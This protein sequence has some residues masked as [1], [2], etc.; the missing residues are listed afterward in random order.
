[1]IQCVS[2]S[3]NTLF[4]RLLLAVNEYELKKRETAPV[5]QT[6]PTG[7]QQDIRTLPDKPPSE[8]LLPR[9]RAASLCLISVRLGCDWL[10]YERCG[11]ER[12]C[13]LFN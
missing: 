6:T 9:R 12:S 8:Q 4:A 1:M 7:K 10:Q 5:C 3:E 11:K 13:I 2:N